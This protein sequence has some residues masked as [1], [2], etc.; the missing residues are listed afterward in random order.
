MELRDQ[1]EHAQVDD[2]NLRGGVRFPVW[3]A[4]ASAF[5]PTV[6]DQALID[7]ELRFTDDL[8]FVDVGP[9]HDHEED[10]NVVRRPPDAFESGVQLFLCR[11]NEHARYIRDDYVRKLRGIIGVF[12]PVLPVFPIFFIFFVFPIV[13]S[14]APSMRL[15]PRLSRPLQR[16]LLGLCHLLP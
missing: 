1:F 7:V 10:A 6:S 12:F 2:G 4:G 14:S 15:L 13:Q 5:L 3:R 16:G 11:V 9:A 8:A